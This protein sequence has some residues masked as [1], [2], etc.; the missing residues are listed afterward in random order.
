M[1]SFLFIDLSIMIYNDFIPRFGSPPRVHHDQGGEFEN[2]LS[3]GFSPSLLLF[4]R[5]PR[6]P[7]DLMFNLTVKERPVYVNKWKK[8]MQ[9]AYALAS[10]S[11]PRE[12]NRTRSD[13]RVQG[14]T[15]ERQTSE[16]E[17]SKTRR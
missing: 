1:S 15:T 12:N 11:R 14:K 2:R 13:S 4:A 5:A 6:L 9:E 10:R 17:C 16:F 7:I 3:T 8:A